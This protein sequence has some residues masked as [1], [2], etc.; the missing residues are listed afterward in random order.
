MYKGN[1][2]QLFPERRSHFG[3]I[4]RQI[5]R[6]RFK[7]KAPFQQHVCI[8]SKNIPPGVL[9]KASGVLHN[10][11]GVL[12]NALGVLRNTSGALRKALGVF[13]TTS[14]VRR[15]ASGVFR[16]AAGV[17]HTHPDILSAQPEVVAGFSRRKQ[18]YKSR[19]TC[20]LYAALKHRFDG[21]LIYCCLKQCT[22]NRVF[23]GI[24]F[25]YHRI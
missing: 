19:R 9:H 5:I 22:Q 23:F 12:R 18:L 25:Y 14:G 6:S 7:K 2:P 3:P 24:T 10:A 15:K 20:P 1:N 8:R 13:R 17:V 16:N 11:S 4:W 21:S